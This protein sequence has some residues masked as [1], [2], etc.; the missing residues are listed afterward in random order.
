MSAS[1]IKVPQGGQKIVPGQA[2]PDNPIIPFIE[3]DGIG[4]D[5][6]PVMIKVVDAA[7]AKAYGGAKKIFWMEVYAGEKSTQMYGSDHYGYDDE[8]KSLVNAERV[9]TSYPLIS[10][11]YFVTFIMLGTM[12]I[13]NLFVGVI[14]NG[15]EEAQGEFQDELRQKHRAKRG[16]LTLGDE[17]A[18]VQEQ[19]EQLAQQ[20]SAIQRR[21]RQSK[22]Y[23]AAVAEEMTGQPVLES[24]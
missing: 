16:H 15:M 11:F 9:S 4:I 3:G 8:M 17:I 18:L 19:L 21:S 5:I 22:Y 12:I 14:V 2:V 23:D 10:P 7:V 1:L 13:L 6:T 20:L 24:P